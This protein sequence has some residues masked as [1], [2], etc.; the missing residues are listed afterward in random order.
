MLLHQRWQEGCTTAKTLFDE[1]KAAGYSGGL[2]VLRDYLRP[3]R[4][5]AQPQ[6]RSTRPPSVRD[7]TGWITRH[8]DSLTRD[9]NL[10]LKSILARCPQLDTVANHVRTVAE[11]MAS[12]SGRTQ[13][14][15]WIDQV[16]TSDLPELVSFVNGIGSDL[17]AVVA[18]LSLPI[19]SGVV[20]G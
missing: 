2:T 12:R 16:T 18:G 13:L 3:L 8:P 6:D 9:E 1:I 14:T 15:G 11:M 19:S 4:S 5:G 17:G 10:K 7:V 20:E